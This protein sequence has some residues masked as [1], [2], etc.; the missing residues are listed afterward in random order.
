MWYVPNLQV[1]EGSSGDQVGEVNT[2]TATYFNVTLNK[3]LKKCDLLSQQTFL[4]GNI[5]ARW[6]VKS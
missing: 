5:F 6:L 2:L 3:G 4:P 1:D